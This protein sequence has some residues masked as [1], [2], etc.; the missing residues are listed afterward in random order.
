[1]GVKDVFAGLDRVEEILSRQRYLVGSQI[2]EADVRLYTTL[3]RFDCVY[4]G[5]FKVLLLQVLNLGYQLGIESDLS[6]VSVTRGVLWTTPTCGATCVIST[7]H[8]GLETPPTDSTL[9]TTTRLAS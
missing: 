7:R 5:H 9:S 4:V 6:F 1:V 8:Q 2:T 3:V